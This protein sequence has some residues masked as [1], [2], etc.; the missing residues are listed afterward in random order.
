MVTQSS[1][2]HRSPGLPLVDDGPDWHQD[3]T[4]EKLYSKES[5]KSWAPTVSRRLNFCWEGLCQDLLGPYILLP[6]VLGERLGGLR[7]ALSRFLIAVS[8]NPGCLSGTHDCGPG[9]SLGTA[10]F[11]LDWIPDP[12]GWGP[13]FAPHHHVAA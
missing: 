12:L 8:A 1:W 2:S 3:L 9:W 13:C 7:L 11:S 10:V 5:L 6:L 4:P